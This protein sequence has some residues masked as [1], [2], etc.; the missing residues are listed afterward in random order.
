MSSNFIGDIFYRPSG[1]IGIKHY[2][3]VGYFHYRYFHHFIVIT[4]KFQFLSYFRGDFGRNLIA[5]DA[6]NLFFIIFAEG[7]CGRVWSRFF[8]RLRHAFSASSIWRK[9]PP[10][11]SSVAWGHVHSRNRPSFT[12][13]IVAAAIM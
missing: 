12:A 11:R 8:S 2:R 6:E 10:R 3:I 7:L 5:V 13:A 4:G 9:I 1:C